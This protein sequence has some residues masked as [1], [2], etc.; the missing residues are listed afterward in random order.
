MDLWG[1][2][3]SL[4]EKHPEVLVWA[5]GLLTSVMLICRGL[6]ELLLLFAHSTKTEIDNKILAFVQKTAE[7]CA[8]ILGWFGLGYPKK[9]M[10]KNLGKNK[11]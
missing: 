9:L 11:E 10:I 7:V 1:F 5:V 6:A 4:L 3:I 8:K 2:L